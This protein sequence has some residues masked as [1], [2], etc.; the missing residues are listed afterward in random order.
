MSAAVPARAGALR[1][2]ARLFPA[3][4]LPGG[5]RRGAA[6][7]RRALPPPGPGASSARPAPPRNPRAHCAGVARG[8]APH[9]ACTRTHSRLRVHC[10]RGAAPTRPTLRVH[11]RAHTHSQLRTLQSSLSTHTTLSTPHI[12]Y[13][14][15]LHTNARL[16][17]PHTHTHKAL[18]TQAY[19]PT[20]TL[21]HIL[22]RP[23]EHSASH[24]G[25]F[26]YRAFILHSD[27]KTKALRDG[28][29][30]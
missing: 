12:L 10:A 5:F 30:C 2:G 22:S 23:Y 14:P 25:K 28:V 11:T 8:H 15:T 9:C 19:T 26:I 13:T 18:H 3:L 20:S 4:P 17:T 27:E 1:P 21:A 6:P 24:T 29:I 7:R 16:Y